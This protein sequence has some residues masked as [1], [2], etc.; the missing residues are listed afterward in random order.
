[1][2]VTAPKCELECRP[3]LRDLIQIRPVVASG[4]LID[5]VPVGMPRPRETAIQYDPVSSHIG[6]ILQVFRTS[7]QPPFPV[8]MQDNNRMTMALAL[9]LFFH[10]TL[11]KGRQHSI[12]LTPVTGGLRTTIMG[13]TA[14]GAVS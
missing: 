7:W 12:S 4:S 11:P 2:L 3:V 5:T 13:N 8:L 10:F 6:P 14:T 1:M 9:T